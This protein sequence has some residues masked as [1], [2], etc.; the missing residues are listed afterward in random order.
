MKRIIGQSGKVIFSDD[1]I[2]YKKSKKRTIRYQYRRC[3]KGWVAWIC[4]PFHSRTY[5]VNS[6]GTKKKYAKAS[7]QRL[8]AND[9]GYIGHITL[10][11]LDEADII[12]IVDK[13]LL[14]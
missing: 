5:G 10:S 8:L 9:Y 4:G 6:Y 1:A 14:D 11:N 12:G 7:L 2:K 13:R 3:D